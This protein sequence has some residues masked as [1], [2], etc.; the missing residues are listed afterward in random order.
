MH[1]H[2]LIQK[3]L[4]AALTAEEAAALA[5][6]MAEDPALAEELAAATRME[7]ALGEALRESSRSALYTR[8][9]QRTADA[10]PT[11]RPARKWPLRQAGIAA[12]IAAMLGG[13]WLLM[14]AGPESPAPLAMEK[15]KAP[16]LTADE[17]MPAPAFTGGSRTARAESAALRRTLRQFHGEWNLRGVPVS[18][19]VAALDA[20][21]KE[22]AAKE[23]AAIP[24]QL[25]ASVRQR[26]TRPEDEPVVTLE[27]PGASLLAQL[28]LAAAQAGLKTVV[29]DT[30]ITLEPDPRADDAT[31]HTW[32]LPLDQ[33]TLTAFIQ[34]A[35]KEAAYAS[36]MPVVLTDNRVTQTVFASRWL[37]VAGLAQTSIETTGVSFTNPTEFDPPQIPHVF[38][39]Y[40]TFAA[41]NWQEKLHTA[42]PLWEQLDNPP[43][44]VD[45][46]AFRDIAGLPAACPSTQQTA[47]CI[48]C[49][50]STDTQVPVQEFEQRK[51]AREQ[52]LAMMRSRQA[53]ASGSQQVETERLLALQANSE[54]TLAQ[55]K[56]DTANSV[57]R[58]IIPVQPNTDDY[59]IDLNLSPEVNEFE[60]FI[61]YGSPIETTGI[62][63]LPGRDAQSTLL[64]FLAAHGSP[65]GS[66]PLSAWKLSTALSEI[67]GHQSTTYDASTGQLTAK[68]TYRQLRAASAALD[69]LRET[70][71]AGFTARMHVIDWPEGYHP[72][73]SEAE[74]TTVTESAWRDELK[75]HRG[76]IKTSDSRQMRPQTANDT[77]TLPEPTELQTPSED[78]TAVTLSGCTALPGTDISAT[79]SISCQRLIGHQTDA[80][81]SRQPV[82]QKDTGSNPLKLSPSHWLRYDL[83][84]HG[85]TAA[86]TVLVSL[87]PSSIA[88]Q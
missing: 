75:R 66:L 36:W 37:D 20:S 62:N 30:A 51:A 21:W 60:G 72:G 58:Y 34:R 77:I 82:I 35:E 26:Y 2:D 83:P 39:N 71:T 6:A 33:A 14:P 43:G 69:A 61:N 53:E 67:T 74:M 7:A 11:P 4:D 63:A 86:R 12:G 24:I 16:R 44:S 41:V 48:Q 47:A 29:T 19:A 27:I 88:P 25:A 54:A 50:Q 46:N 87:Q 81:G 28:N 17:A 9:F 15:K 64:S 68:G 23:Y 38:G 85:S 32:T 56:A 65:Q 22:H 55:A 31:E 5:A 57:P 18:Q 76:L 73:G 49:H 79:V 8:R 78:H 10:L 45:F 84:A 40:Q 80:S 3:H 70:A 1:P 42:L 13:A 59:G 52:L